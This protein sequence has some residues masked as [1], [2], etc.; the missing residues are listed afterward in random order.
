MKLIHLNPIQLASFLT[1]KTVR[2]KNTKNKSSVKDDLLRTFKINY[3]ERVGNHAETNEQFITAN[4]SDVDDG[5]E[6][7]FRNL[8]TDAIDVIV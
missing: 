4:V 3:V 7:K 8:Y 2:Y 6:K 5:G 1:N